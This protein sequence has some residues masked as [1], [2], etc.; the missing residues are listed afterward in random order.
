MTDLETESTAAEARD[1]E[2]TPSGQLVGKQLGWYRVEALIGEGAMGEVYR[3]LHEPLARPVAIKTLKPDVATNRAVVERFFAEARAV[4]LI[5]HENIVECTDLVGDQGGQSYIVMELLEGLTL[6]A[7]LRQSGRFAAKRAVHVAAQIA[8]AIAA[9]HDKGIVHRDLKPDNVFLIRRAGSS[10]YVKVLDFGIARL[11]PDIGGVGTT[12]SGAL[13]GTPAYMSPE[14]A[15]GDKAGPAAD[16]YALG[17]ILY[18]MLVGKPPFAAAT[19]PLML[20]AHIN[21]APPRI[22]DPEVPRALADLVAS[23]LEKEPKARPASMA[24]VHVAL[25]ESAGLANDVD[26]PQPAVVTTRSTAAIGLAATHADVGA[27]S[28]GGASGYVSRSTPRRWRGRAWMFAGVALAAI[29][30]AAVYV[31]TRSTNGEHSVSTPAATPA[32]TPATTP[33]PRGS[34]AVALVIEGQESWLDHG[35]LEAVK[36]AVDRAQ[37]SAAGPDGSRG[38]VISYSTGADVVLPMGELGRLTGNSLGSA[39]DYRGRL[40]SDMVQGTIMAMAELAHVNTSAKAMIVIGD[41]GDSNPVNAVMTLR[42]T[43]IEA[44]SRGIRVYAVIYRST[45]TGDHIVINELAPEVKAVT[46]VDGLVAELRAFVA[47][48]RMHAM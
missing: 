23:M 19:M 30:T 25:L 32:P 7:A 35:T 26:A 5:R 39:R 29:A 38:M 48:V 24:A 10:D 6:A 47:D 34:I 1:N 15:R 2:Q 16:I 17:A 8:D 42:H 36:A 27:S 12:Q 45:V 46:T 3:A 14:Q 31:A 13:I 40:G 43:M 18:Q 21:E 22:D 4:N 41:G 33:V 44:S 37:L 11:R 20:I 9:A 28:I